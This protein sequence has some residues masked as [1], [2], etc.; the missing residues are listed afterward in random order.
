MCVCNR[1]W[2]EREGER[3]HMG[4]AGHGGV[5]VRTV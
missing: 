2:R 4:L 3:E 5:E 1:M